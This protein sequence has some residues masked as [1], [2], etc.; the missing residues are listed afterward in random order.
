MTLATAEETKGK[1]ETDARRRRGPGRVVDLRGRRLHLH[2]LRPSR[3]LPSR[4]HGKLS[5]PRRML[6]SLIRR[7]KAACPAFVV[8]G[9][10]RGASRTRT[11]A[12][13]RGALQ[14]EILGFAKPAV[15]FASLEY[16]AGAAGAAVRGKE[17][18]GYAARVVRFPVE[19]ADR[20]IRSSNSGVDRQRKI[21]VIYTGCIPAV[22]PIDGVARPILENLDFAVFEII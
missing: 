5:G 14:R 6:R 11:G 17:F 15:P 12:A 2:H 9:I 3:A 20:S 16:A 10:R 7:E 22:T 21:S 1:N 19:R 13:Q 18:L 4:L 8:D